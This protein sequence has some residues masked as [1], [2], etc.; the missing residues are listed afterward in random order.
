MNRRLQ[1]FV[2][3]RHLQGIG[4]KRREA[5]QVGKDLQSFVSSLFSLGLNLVGLFLQSLRQLL[6]FVVPEKNKYD[7]IQTA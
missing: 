6:G 7:S 1:T 4:V 3:N 2:L 5:G